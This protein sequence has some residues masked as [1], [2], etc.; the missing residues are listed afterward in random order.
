MF[1]VEFEFVV[2]PKFQ[3]RPV[4]RCF[5][6]PCPLITLYPTIAQMSYSFHVTNLT[7]SCEAEQSSL[8]CVS[9]TD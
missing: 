3:Q 2:Q 8:P 4:F 1:S 9:A 7:S 5:T 6:V